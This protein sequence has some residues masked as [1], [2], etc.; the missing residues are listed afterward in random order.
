MDKWIKEM[1]KNSNEVISAS[2]GD[3][4]NNEP[5]VSYV[6]EYDANEITLG[7]D[8]FTIEQLEVL[9]KHMKKYNT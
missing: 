8:D 2:P 5:S 9:I 6:P 3:L 4:T 1:E 7:G